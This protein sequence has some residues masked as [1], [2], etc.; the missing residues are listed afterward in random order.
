MYIFLI[1]Q[2]VP[3]IMLFHLIWWFHR[4][5]DFEAMKAGILAIWPWLSYQYKENT[6]VDLPSS[7][8]KVVIQLQSNFGSNVPVKIDFKKRIKV[9]TKLIIRTNLCI[10][11]HSIVKFMQVLF[12]AANHGNQKKLNPIHATHP[13]CLYFWDTLF[14]WYI[15][16]NSPLNSANSSLFSELT[17]VW[18]VVG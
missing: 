18:L 3:Q 16:A 6:L 13:A 12:L 17:L 5:K 14:F 8:L 1:H 2:N 11:I 9:V 10:D 4:S 7:V 15:S